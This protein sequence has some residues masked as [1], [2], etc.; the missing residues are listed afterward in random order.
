MTPAIDTIEANGEPRLIAEQGI[1]VRVFQGL[2]GVGD[3]LRITLAPWPVLERVL[4][5]LRGAMP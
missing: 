3:A 1:A 2:R 5:A 4:V